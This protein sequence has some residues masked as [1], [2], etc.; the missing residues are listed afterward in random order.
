MFLA[1]TN[2]ISEA[3]QA[4]P[5]PQVLDWL[6]KHE[7]DLFISAVTIAEIQSGISRLEDGPKQ[8]KLQKWFD[9]LRELYRG[10]ILAFDEPVAITWGKMNASLVRKGR[11]LPAADSFL[12]ATALHHDLTVATRNERDFA[13]AGVTTVNPWLLK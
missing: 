12:A 6:S 5:Q 11:R 7:T 1:D 10:A 3:R 9:T 4:C 13:D 8:A 2:L